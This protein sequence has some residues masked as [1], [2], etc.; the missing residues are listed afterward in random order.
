MQN[1]GQPGCKIPPVPYTAFPSL[2]SPDDKVRRHLV[3]LKY[4]TLNINP[5]L[6]YPEVRFPPNFIINPD[7]SAPLALQSRSARLV[8]PG[9]LMQ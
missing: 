2:I 5:L 9:C 4:W 6:V 8:L 1:V 7:F 3:Y